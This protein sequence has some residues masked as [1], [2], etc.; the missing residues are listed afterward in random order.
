ML[1]EVAVVNMTYREAASHRNI[2]PHHGGNVADSAAVTLCIHIHTSPMTY[3][4][5]LR[6]TY[7]ILDYSH[8]RAVASCDAHDAVGASHLGIDLDAGC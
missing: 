3:I 5:V 1:Y 2:G 7:S 6:C 4:T 8:I